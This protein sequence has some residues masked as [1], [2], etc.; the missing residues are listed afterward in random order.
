MKWQELY[1]EKYCHLY[2]TPSTIRVSY[3]GTLE[4]I[5]FYLY[6]GPLYEKFPAVLPYSTVLFNSNPGT[7]ITNSTFHAPLL[8]AGRPSRQIYALRLSLSMSC[9]LLVGWTCAC[10][11]ICCANLYLKCLDHFNYMNA[12]SLPNPHIPFQPLR[13]S[14]WSTYSSFIHSVMWECRFRTLYRKDDRPCELAAGI[15]TTQGH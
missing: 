2:M 9:I 13:M 6:Y 14:K 5:S 3:K 7:T 4:Q 10:T 8:K 1:M 11:L 15:D 12:K